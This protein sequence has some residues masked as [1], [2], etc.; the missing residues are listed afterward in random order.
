MAE[1][2][3]A[4]GAGQAG[5]P[6]LDF[7]AFPNQIFWLAVFLLILFLIVSRVVL[8]RIEGIQDARKNRI[9]EDLE[10]A[11]RAAAEAETARVK[12]ARLLTEAKSEAEGIAAEA[13]AGIREI[14]DR[15]MARVG[16]E[17]A[18]M[19]EES[20][21]RISEIRAA[22]PGNI[23]E[24]VASVVPEIINY[25][26]PS[27]SAAGAAQPVVRSGPDGGGR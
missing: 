25:I 13:R 19:A 7:A 2:K 20:E 16:D 10:E 27:R 23:Q 8:P 11:D 21:N 14:Q 18:V 17:I 5:I 12:T 26:L 24:I 4:A 22:A 9:S 15:E 6:Q 1:E 3:T